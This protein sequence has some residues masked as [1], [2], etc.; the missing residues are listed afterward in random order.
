MILPAHLQLPNHQPASL[1]SKSY[2]GRNVIKASGDGSPCD[3]NQ[4]RDGG[5]SSIM[6]GPCLGHH[7]QGYLHVW[8][9][10][11]R[12]IGHRDAFSRPQLIATSLVFP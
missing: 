11:I 7:Y 5:G 6:D 10:Q 4:G 1:I 9:I 3:E 2:V 8:E 12:E